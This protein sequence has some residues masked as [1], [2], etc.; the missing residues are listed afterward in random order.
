MPLYGLSIWALPYLMS[1]GYTIEQATIFA[2]EATSVLKRGLDTDYID[3][4]EV[5]DSIAKTMVEAG[6]P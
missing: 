3:P 2:K 6:A 5:V 1:Q 4:D